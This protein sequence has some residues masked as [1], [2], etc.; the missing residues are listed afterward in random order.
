MLDQQRLRTDL[1]KWHQQQQ[2][3]CPQVVPY[4]ISAPYCPPQ[5]EKLFLPSDFNSNDRTKLGLDILGGEEL[6]LRKGEANDALHS[7]REHI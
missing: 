2:Q 6:K 5:E 1:K 3:I 7:L 4:I